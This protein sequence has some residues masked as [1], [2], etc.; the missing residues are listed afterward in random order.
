MIL[1]VTPNPAVDH[2]YFV[3]GL[4]QN[5]T[6][7]VSRVETDAGGKSVNVA[8]VLAAL[9]NV[10]VATG[11]VAGGNGAFVRQRLD[12]EAVRH[13]FVE[14]SGET[15]ANVL[16]EDGSG[17]PPTVL[18][19]PGPETGGVE[20][21]LLVAKIAT[22]GP[23]CSHIVLGGS[24]PTGL[25]ERDFAT[26]VSVAAGTGAKAVVD[27]DGEALRLA[28]QAGADIVKPNVK[29]AGRLLGRDVTGLEGAQAAAEAI[30]KT[31]RPASGEG[32][33]IVSAGSLGA[34]M[35]CSAGVF[36]GEAITVEPKSTIGSGDSM[37]AGIL[38]ATLAG[39]GPLD[40][41]SFGLAAG[42]ATATT[43]GSRIASRDEVF[44]LLPSAKVR[45]AK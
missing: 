34:A 32:V 15:R 35:A 18:S 17:L 29:E 21:E 31:M 41:L 10:V 37:V 40:Q 20:F 14:V 36:L 2:V 44:G 28:V 16:V 22:H 19:A 38:H 12:S 25:S 3:N 5:D 9:G 26:L 45:A 13:D 24:M 8:R 1:T 6:N 7:R 39:M 11:L 33:A 4:R 23:K 30:L 42:A 27:A 43:D